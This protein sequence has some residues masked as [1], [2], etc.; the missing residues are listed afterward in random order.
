MEKQIVN[1]SHEE[2]MT[3]KLIAALA[4]GTLPEEKP[5]QAPAPQRS[6]NLEYAVEGLHALEQW[7]LEHSRLL[8][9]RDYLVGLALL[10][11]LREH[12]TSELPM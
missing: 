4:S 3:L 2:A 10:D 5:L 11:D 6:F 8:P 9:R 7:L 1:S 12:I